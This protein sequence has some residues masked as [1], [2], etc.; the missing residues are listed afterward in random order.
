MQTK[1][2]EIAVGVFVAAGIAALFML[3]MKVSNL[4]S[5]T[6]SNGYT[7]TA[8]FE[9]I[10]GLKV[11]SP[12]S[13]GGV[14]VGRVIG[15][16]YDQSKYEAEVTMIIDARYNRFPVDTTASVFTSGLLGEQ[17]VNLDP[18]G[19]DEYLKNGDEIHMTQSAL[20]LEQL[21]GRFLYSA[22]EGSNSGSGTK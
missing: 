8:R 5:S 21:I 12:V 22:S 6:I 16:K 2:V 3:A 18:G 7:V 14:R 15:I 1:L 13:A 17:Y 4:A 10:G 9:N 19:A 20:V 11:Q